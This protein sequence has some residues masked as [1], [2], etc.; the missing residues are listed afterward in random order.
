LIAARVL[1]ILAASVNAADACATIRRAFASAVRPLGLR[2]ALPSV[3]EDQLSDLPQDVSL[4]YYYSLDA[5]PDV[6]TDETH[7]LLLSAPYAFSSRWDAQLLRVLRSVGAHTLLTG[8]MRFC[9][10]ADEKP[11]SPMD[12][13]TQRLPK[14]GRSLSSL[15]QNLPDIRKRESPQPRIHQPDAHIRPEKE[16]CSEAYL[17]ALK[18]SLG[19]NSVSIGR[20]LALVCAEAPVKTL[21]VDPALL[22][23]P[24]SFLQDCDL[25][26]E[27]LSLAA[28][29][30]GYAVYA[31]HEAWMWPVCELPARKLVR[32]GADVLPG[33]TMARFEQLTGFHYDQPHTVGKAAMGLFTADD[34]YAQ[35]MP[36]NLILGQKARSARMRLRETHFPLLVSAYIDLPSPRNSPAFYLLRFGFLRRIASLPL[37]LFTGG[38]QERALRASFPNTQSYPSQ[39]LLP[40]SLLQEGMKPHQHFVRSKPLLM[41]KAAKKYAEHTHVA[42]VDMDILPHPV[43]PEAVPQLHAL[44]DDRIHMATV[45]GIPDASFLLIPV[46]YLPYLARETLSITQLDAELK[47]DFSEEVLWQRLFHKKPEWFAIHPMPRRRLLFLSLFDS[48]LLSCSLKAHLA[49]LPEVY[50]P[51]APDHAKSSLTKEF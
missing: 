22:A 26:P 34:V 15:R 39:G 20:G 40:L 37:L 13:P 42:W 4:L 14:L 21:I 35:R 19:K 46:Q 43:C 8:Q 48:Q 6:L 24:V 29:V 16:K 17:P 27:T 32:P 44:M 45:D 51:S 49:D 12:A 18:E 10:L 50:R 28:Y 36:G 33:S 5:L 7:F 25:T 41:L 3:L 1:V 38:S 9:P 47:R 31:L 30:A 11:V 2:F 23:G